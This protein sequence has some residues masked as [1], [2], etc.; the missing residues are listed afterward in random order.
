MLP[1]S[2]G[3]EV[4]Q[5]VVFSSF[6][7]SFLGLR[8]SEVGLGIYIP[9]NADTSDFWK[10]LWVI[11]S[12]RY[13]LWVCASVLQS[14]VLQRVRR[15][16]ATEQ[17]V[18]RRRAATAPRTGEHSEREAS[19]GGA[20]SFFL[21]PSHRVTQEGSSPLPRAPPPLPSD[22]RTGSA[23]FGSPHSVPHFTSPLAGTATVL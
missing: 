9:G 14:M 21:Y 20:R 22:E 4:S 11:L 13:I 1:N 7:L 10:L 8:R 5:G 17:P 19:F 12:Q 6:Q 16:T 15:N 3:S 18:Y 23:H 2:S